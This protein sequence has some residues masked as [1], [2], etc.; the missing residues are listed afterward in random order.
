MGFV[1]ERVPEN[2]RKDFK[3]PSYYKVVT[4][5]YWTIDR[6][7]SIILFKYWTNIDEPS[8]KYF[9]FIW[10]DE[11]VNLTFICEIPDVNT[12]KWSIKN[13]SIPKPV[14]GEKNKIL[15]ELREAMSVYGFSG[16]SFA[17]V[18]AEEVIIDF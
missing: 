12:V 7:K 17:K 10:K 6:E 9:A 11:I 3:I 18:K 1:N 15:D 4:P 2:E 8:E 14:E 5:K 13:I 16:Y